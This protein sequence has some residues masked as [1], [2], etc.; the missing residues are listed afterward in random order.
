MTR[1]F[2]DANILLDITYASRPFSEES[3][4]LYR[5]LLEQRDRYELYTSC[6]LLT[7]VYYVLSKQLDSESVLKKLKILNRV[8]K[9]IEFGN[10][11]VDE[12]IYLM[13]KDENYKDLE[14]TIQYVMARK[15]RCDYIV[16][17]DKTFMSYD[18]PLL[19][20]TAALRLLKEHK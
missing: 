18:I 20:S 5:F 10:R 9:V 15:Q 6:D 11:E 13:E 16:T 4:E 3:G 19:D 1:I 8:M 7:T 17:N 12:A 2:L 14:D